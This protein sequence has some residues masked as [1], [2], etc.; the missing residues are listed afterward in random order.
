MWS[1]KYNYYNIQSD[2]YFSQKTDTERV[3]NIL[4]ETDCFIQKNHQSFT[5]A[6]TFPWVDVIIVET[7][8]GNF[9]AT[10]KPFPQ[11]N[12]IAIVCSKATEIDQLVYKNVFLSIA[13]K[14]NW[15]LFLEA[16]DNGNENI[17]IKFE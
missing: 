11:V 4:L 2:K 10:D 8:D 13:D 5:N 15:K 3:V 17:E 7:A 9:S 16:D 14:L 12:L 1:D 6:E